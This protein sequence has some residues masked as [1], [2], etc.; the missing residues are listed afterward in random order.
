MGGALSYAAGWEWIFWF[1]A[2]VAGLCL[3]LMGLFL[4]E[5][6]RSIVGDGSVRPAAHLC[7]PTPLMRHWKKEESGR[8]RPKHGGRM[9][10]PLRSLRL[11]LRPD[12]AVLILAQGLMYIVYTCVTASLSTLMIEIYGLNQLQAGLI[13]LPFGLG[14]MASTFVSGWLL[15][16]A[17]REARKRLGLSTD[18]AR[19][20]DLDTFPVEKAR[21]SVMWVPM[22]TS[23]LSVV[24]FGWVLHSK[25]VRCSLPIITALCRFSVQFIYSISPTNGKKM[26]NTAHSHSISSSIHCR[27]SLAVGFQCKQ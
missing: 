26:A 3:V 21:L 9:P 19:G 11:L 27:T 4:P 18:R 10:N 16:R 24:A 20:D 23:C 14:G 25:L 6:A 15:D 13:Y 8:R 22:A 17:Y 1:L 2:L 5:T 12:N 7:L